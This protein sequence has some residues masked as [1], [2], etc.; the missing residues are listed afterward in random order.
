M[1]PF[2][3]L[4]VNVPPEANSETSSQR[5]ATQTDDDGLIA[6]LSLNRALISVS[7]LYIFIRKVT[8]SIHS[9]AEQ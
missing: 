5:N 6:V 3:K 4:K 1:H 2:Q 9:K 8:R 7:Y